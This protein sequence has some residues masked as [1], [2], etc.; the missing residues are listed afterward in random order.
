M[1][2][3][4]QADSQRGE[5][6]KRDLRDVQAACDEPIALRKEIQKR[7]GFRPLT[8]REIREAIEFGRK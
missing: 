7:P 1:I 8:M 2:R 5:S 6:K 4:P 3:T